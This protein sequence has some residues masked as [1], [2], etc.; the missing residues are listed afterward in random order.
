MKQM[1]L[2][3]KYPVYTIEMQKD[4][5]RYNTMDN[6]IDY[7]LGEIEGH[8]A[9]TYIALFDHYN[10]TKNL[11]NGEINPEIIN[12]YDIVF[13]FGIKI[14]NPQVLAVRPRS[15]GI[16]EMQDCFVISFMEAPMPIA[17]EAMETWARG[18]KI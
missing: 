12:A 14:P 16:A 6:V 10:H 4:E 5:M 15:I 1:L 2:Q 3:E 17:N 9:A 8:P 13:C 18:L 7:F 11:E